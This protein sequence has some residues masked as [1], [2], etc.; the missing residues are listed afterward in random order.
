VLSASIDTCS[1]TSL[2]LDP[3]WFFSITVSQSFIS[4]LPCLS[5]RFSLLPL[6]AF[7]PNRWQESVK[8]FSLRQMLNVRL[9]WFSFA[10]ENRPKR[11]AKKMRFD[12]LLNERLP[13][14]QMVV[15]ICVN[16]HCHIIKFLTYIHIERDY[17]NF[18]QLTIIKATGKSKPYL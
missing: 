5:V 10:N 9:S 6:P 15:H 3:L 8:A 17:T 12:W 11:R 7:D 14:L 18:V 16:W 1:Y 13:K 2:A 4:A